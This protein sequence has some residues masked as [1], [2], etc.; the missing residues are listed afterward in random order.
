[1]AIHGSCKFW[2]CRLLKTKNTRQNPDQ[3]RTN[4][5]ARIYLK[6]TFPYNNPFS[7]FFVQRP[8]WFAFATK[9]IYGRWSKHFEK[10]ENTVPTSKSLEFPLWIRKNN[11]NAQIHGE[12]E[13]KT[14]PSFLFLQTEYS[15]EITQNNS[16]NLVL[17]SRYHIARQESFTRD[18]L[19]H[20]AVQLD[21]KSMYTNI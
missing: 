13:G 14:R 3:E 6:T 12:R 11:R 8:T 15:I 16:Q 18:L 4:Q 20:L 7:C 19:A 9:G 10:L 17:I 5:N 21:I 2:I 1:M